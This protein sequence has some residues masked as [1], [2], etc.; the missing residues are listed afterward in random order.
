MKKLI[1]LV[2]FLGFLGVLAAGAYVFRDK[3]D[4]T[5]VGLKIDT[6]PTATVYLDGVELGSTPYASKTHKAGTY[7]VKLVPTSPGSTPLAS[8]EKRLT[9][10]PQT[11]AVISRNFAESPLDTSGFTLTYTP[12]TS[13][14]TYLSVISDPDT[15]NLA[16][17]GQPQGFTPATRLETSPGAHQ[18]TFSSPG[19]QGIELSVN[20]A[21]G[22][23]L[24]VEIKL[25]LDQLQIELPS[26]SPDPLPSSTPSGELAATASAAPAL[27][28]PYVIIQETGTGWLRVRQEPSSTGLEIG[29]ATVGEKYQYLG[30]T[31]ETGWHKIEF[32]DLPGWV[33][34]RYTELIK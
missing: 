27:T 25:A 6:I 32:T 34:A 3:F 19:Y 31:T 2:I 22:F 9:L 10:A 13:G 26:P 5:P 12:D 17:D 23:N 30:T 18:L 8:W 1:I 24:M 28:P 33:S 11:T 20:A 14:G 29:R 7:V 21:E 15:I 16:L 4:K